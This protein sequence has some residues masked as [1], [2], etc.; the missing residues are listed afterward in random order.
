LLR[1]L[2]KYNMFFMYTFEFEFRFGYFS[3][4][5]LLAIALKI[6]F[7]TKHKRHSK[8]HMVYM[9]R[10]TQSENLAPLTLLSHDHNL[11]TMRMSNPIWS[12]I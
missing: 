2:L 1:F 5:D 7:G 6:A 3:E 9:N 12:L 10:L 8:R 11:L 4:F